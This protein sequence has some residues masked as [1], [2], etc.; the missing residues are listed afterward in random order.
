[1]DRPGLSR[2]VVLLS[3]AIFFTDA[4]HSTVIPIFPG[5]AKGVGASL[6]MLGSYG[7]VAA[8]AMLLLSLPLGQLSDRYGRRRMM[9][10]GLI[11]FIVVP[12]SYMA[13]QS[14]YHL[15]PIRIALG[16]GVGLIFGN[17]FLLMSEVAEEGFRN[18]AQG[19]YMTSM[20][21]GFTLGPLV[22]GFAAKLV[23]P[24]LSFK[25]SSGFAVLG[26]LLLL[27][28]K[29]KRVKES[30][31]TEARAGLSELVRDPRIIAS[32]VANFV[33]S[34][35][36][37]AVTLFFPVYGSDIGLDEADVGIGFTSRGLASTAVRLPVGSLTRRIKALNLM[38]AGL[39]LSAATM[40]TVSNSSGLV[41]VSV[42]MGVQGVAYG[43]YLTSGNVYV[44]EEAP[45]DRKATAMAVYSMFGNIGGI[46][47]PVTLGVIAERTGARGALQFS[48]AAT[49]LGVALAMLLARRE[50]GSPDLAS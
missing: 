30:G 4:S 37:N 9:V 7:S 43:V 18:V 2:D 40:F 28:V 21:L 50:A 45:R 35:M 36:F 39:L 17:G 48:A 33:N 20:G 11:L 41:L 8:M 19:L 1:M 34:L 44:S 46:V 29:E 47:G 14:P 25:I 12:L 23:A 26:L 13:A 32:G 27:M 5:Y 6:S 22:G 24:N 15:Y 42:L 31:K 3:L 38:A 10:P 49:L 16:L